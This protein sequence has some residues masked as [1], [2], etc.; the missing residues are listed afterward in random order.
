[1]NIGNLFGVWS[2]L[3]GLP[4]RWGGA[5]PREPNPPGTAKRKA[6]AKKARKRAHKQRMRGKK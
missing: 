2:D 4:Q 6:K 3:A 1:M 5:A